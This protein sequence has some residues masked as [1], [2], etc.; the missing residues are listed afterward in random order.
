LQKKD[1]MV[2]TIGSVVNH[3]HWIETQS[4]SPQAIHH[5]TISIHRKRG[6]QGTAFLCF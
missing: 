2:A 5:E 6:C 3:V 4:P 1:Q